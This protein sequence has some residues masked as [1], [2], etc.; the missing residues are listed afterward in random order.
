MQVCCGDV[1]LIIVGVIDLVVVCYG[2]LLLDLDVVLVGVD[3]VVF[4]ILFDYCLCNVCVV[5]VCGVK[6]Q[7]FGYIYG[8]QIIGMD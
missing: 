6:L 5:V 8:G 7:L 2:L 4:V 3:F 1:V